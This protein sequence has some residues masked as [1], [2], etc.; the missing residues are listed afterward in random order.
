MSR[1]RTPG[2]QLDN[3]GKAFAGVLVLIHVAHF[4]AVC[5]APLLAVELRIGSLFSSRLRTTRGASWRRMHTPTDQPTKSDQ[6]SGTIVP[7]PLLSCRQITVSM[8]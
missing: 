7:G 1:V 4:E 5:R 8:P 3:A 2:Q 6:L